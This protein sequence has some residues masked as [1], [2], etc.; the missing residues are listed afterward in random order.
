M[1][2]R[3]GD[4]VGERNPNW[5]GGRSVASNGYV[6]IRVGVGHPL[7]DVR[8]Y[9]YEHR[10][11]ASEKLGRRVLPSEHVHHIDGDKTNN[12]ENNLEVL[13]QAEHRC[14][15]READRGLRLPGEDNPLI[16]CACGCGERFARFDESNRPRSF[17]PGHNSS[18][19]P[20]IDAVIAGLASGPLHRRVLAERIGIPLRATVTCLSKLHRRGVVANQG[21]GRWGLADG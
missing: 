13:S 21:R 6:L 5:R 20:T 4:L 1:G 18:P 3:P 11:V 9:A 14:E 17:I 16:E 12:T 7:A 8:G 2:A 19:S 10:L 15:H